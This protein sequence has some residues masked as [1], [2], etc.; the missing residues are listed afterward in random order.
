MRFRLNLR[1]RRAI[2]ANSY[3]SEPGLH[4][5]SHCHADVYVSRQTEVG[6]GSETDH[7]EFLS[8]LQVCSD[9]TDTDNAASYEPGDAIFDKPSVSA[10]TA[11][12]TA[13]FTANLIEDKIRA[14]ETFAAT[15][16]STRSG[17]ISV[18]GKQV[19]P[20]TKAT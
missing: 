12:G 19:R 9:F 16:I 5:I 3:Q 14:G 6:T 11:A 17:A 20:I 18:L 13:Q 2:L 8:G 4:L 10:A 15:N 1:I 7:T